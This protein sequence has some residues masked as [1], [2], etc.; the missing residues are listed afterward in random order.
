M[1][2]NPGLKK[3]FDDVNSGTPGEQPNN[4][5]HGAYRDLGLRGLMTSVGDFSPA[6]YF[7]DYSLE[8]QNN[9]TANLKK[10]IPDLFAPFKTFN[11]ATP[12]A[13]VYQDQLAIT[14]SNPIGLLARASLPEYSLKAAYPTFKLFLM[15]EDSTGIYYC[16]DDFYSYASVLHIETED[17]V[18]RG[19][20]AQLTLTNLTG[21]FS[22]KL[23]DSSTLGKLEQHYNKFLPKQAMSSDG[24][25][26]V[27]QAG[28]ETTV[29]AQEQLGGENRQE[30]IDTNGRPKE[31]P[32]RYFALQTGTK[33]QIRMGF[34]NNPDKLEPVF[35][36]VITEIEG[37][38]IINVVAQGYMIELTQPCPDD[39]NTDG[40]S[41]IGMVGEIFKNGLNLVTDVCTVSLGA[42]WQ[43][44]KNI[45]SLQKAPAYGGLRIFGDSGDSGSI[46]ASLLKASPA[47]HFGHW[48]VAQIT[49]AYLK[50]FTWAG[51]VGS[52]MSDNSE[53][54]ALV[55]TLN[56][57]RDENI[58]INH[59]VNWDGSFQAG[60][61]KRSFDFETPAMVL[62]TPPEYHIPNSTNLTPW[63]IIKDVSRRYPEYILDVKPYGF[64][65]QADATLVFAHPL[66]WYYSR[67]KGF[68][69]T[70]PPLVPQDQNAFMT[71]WVSGGGRARFLA[72]YTEYIGSGA[73]TGDVSV[74]SAED[75]AAQM[76]NNPVFA[77]AKLQEIVGDLNSGPKAALARSF[78]GWFQGNVRA[79]V[80]AFDGLLKD[81]RKTIG[82]ISDPNSALT[83]NPAARVKAVRQYH[84]VDHNTIIHNGITVNSK[85]NN[86]IS[87]CGTTVVANAMIP[88]HHRRVVDVNGQVINPK[89][90]IPNTKH[91]IFQSYAQSFLKDEISRMYRGE[92][93][94]TLMP[95]IRKFDVLLISDPSTGMVG[96][97]EVES[98]IHTIDQD[99]GA[100]TI[101]R[102]RAMVMINEAA[103]ASILGALFQS[104]MLAGA[105]IQGI[106]DAYNDMTSLSKGVGGWGGGLLIAAGATAAILAAPP[107][108]VTLALGAGGLM[109]MAS[110][111]AGMQTTLNPV[112]L[113][114]LSRFGKPWVGGLEGYRVVD[115]A[116]YAF[117]KFN[118]AVQEE[119]APTI[120]SYRMLQ[121]GLY[122]YGQPTVVIDTS[123]T[124]LPSSAGSGFGGKTNPTPQVS[125]SLSA[126][127]AQNNDVPYSLLRAMAGQESGGKQT[128]SNGQIVTS[129]KGALGAL[130]L[131]PATAKGLGVD[132]TDP[133]SNINGGAKYIRQMFNRYGR[134]DLA[135]AAYNAGPV[136]VSGGG[137][138]GKHVFIPKHAP[139]IPNIKETQQYVANI[140]ANSGLNA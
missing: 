90:N 69:E 61:M 28:V 80:D 47:K 64:P 52:W 119:I 4:A 5:Q 62:S 49:D 97:V 91:P 105:M 13:S 126:L 3:S 15:E 135:L 9:A 107:V 51:L 68:N 81:M 104:T 1:L 86:T 35:Q 56:D 36:G 79:S 82:F 17:D 115:L 129:S 55:R 42:S 98:V 96:P 31:V 76:D 8:L 33:I 71:W 122:P 58:L 84:F 85:I 130:Q 12:G 66:D 45:I 113:A 94:L 137:Y 67:A 88:S 26:T 127:P 140:M 23:L 29:L 95:K 99:M 30:G 34:D 72:A 38:E 87:L 124:V 18:N 103:S 32:L 19:A 63:Q 111:M 74:P 2:A 6:S 114:P 70:T 39:L 54:G 120:E 106:P 7:K 16:F 117:G 125:K 43:D 20:T 25:A 22:H 102:P 121:K 41:P 27:G 136:N 131:M 75:V 10:L 89:E 109:F 77:E 73:N 118:Q 132:P 128:T 50:G 37:E 138:N 53:L 11:A 116:S 134:W 21:M 44:I 93:L 100:V 123:G 59:I 46:I 83:G 40:Y 101:V 112:L 108:M 60:I 57:R 139:C 24:S 14:D 48:Q 65:Y 92:I 78:L 133:Q 110:A